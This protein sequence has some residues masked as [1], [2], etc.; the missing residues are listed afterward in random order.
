MDI[1]QNTEKTLDHH[2][3]LIN[4]AIMDILEHWQTVPLWIIDKLCNYGYS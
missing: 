4:C 3:P 1:Y 2:G